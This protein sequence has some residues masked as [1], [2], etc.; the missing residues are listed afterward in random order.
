VPDPAHASYRSFASFSDPD[1]NGWL[2]Q[3][4]TT[5]LAGRIDCRGHD[6]RIGERPGGRFRRAEHAHRRLRGDARPSRRRTGRS[7]T[8][9]YMVAEQSGKELPT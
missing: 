5:R 1:G 6:V 8:P 4:V 3:E 9:A 2:L 7:G